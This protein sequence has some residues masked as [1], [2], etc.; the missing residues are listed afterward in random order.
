M[1][2]VTDTSL[3]QKIRLKNQFRALD[4][5]E[6]EYLDSV[7]ESTRAKEAAVQKETSEQLEIF[8]RQQAE[9]EKSAVGD[10]GSGSPIGEE[11]QWT[12]RK[13]KKG[14]EKETFKGLKL[15]KT[16][17]ATEDSFSAPI[18]SAAAAEKEQTPAKVA[19]VASTDPPVASSSGSNVNV[20][21][22]APDKGKPVVKPPAAKV[23]PPSKPAVLGLGGYSS[24]ED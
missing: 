14:K 16:S 1:P 13:R 22:Q 21:K 10:Q 9:A 8:R 19:S 23:P 18:Q 5:D 6:V 20:N 15:R 4:E 7:L 24:D 12:T 3:S 2:C 17:S 11:E